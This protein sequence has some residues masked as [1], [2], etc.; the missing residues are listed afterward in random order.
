MSAEKKHCSNCEYQL[1]PY[2]KFCPN[3]GQKVDDKL[4]MRVLFHNTITNYF[5]V[6]ARFFR[7]FIPLLIK[8]GFLAKEFIKGR[9]LLYLHPAQFYLFASIIFF[10]LFSIATRSSQRNFDNSIKKTFGKEKAITDEV[11]RVR[12]SITNALEV[13]MTN[14]EGTDSLAIA[15]M[16]AFLNS[17][18]GSIASDSVKVKKNKKKNKN[19]HAQLFGLNFDMVLLDSLEQSNATEEEKMKAI[20]Y[21]ESHGI[22]SK[23]VAKQVI[24]FRAN[25]GVGLLKSFFDTI[26]ISMFFLIPVFAFLL[27]ILYRKQGRFAHH[28][29]FSFYYFAFMFLATSI[30]FMANYIVDIPNVID[31]LLIFSTFFYL[32]ISLKRFYGQGYIK[33][34]I[35]TCILSFVYLIFVVPVTFVMLWV[36]SFFLY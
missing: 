26:P 5:S 7:S 34:F 16:K 15:K 30:I 4:N 19:I 23:F 18:N 8:P 3:C 10:F 36:V 28:M 20:G 24:K 31:F 14:M 21:T 2:H 11:N 1:T 22:F 9:R 27:K 35:K 6:D 32:I 13:Q 25:K 17:N 29:V 12:D 33:T